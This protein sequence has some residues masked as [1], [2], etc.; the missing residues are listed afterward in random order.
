MLIGP[1]VKAVLIVAQF[2]FFCVILLHSN[3]NWDFGPLRWVFVSPLYHRWHHTTE[4]E[5]LDK[6]FAG[7]FPIWDVL[8]GTAHFP[9]REPTRFGVNHEAPPETLPGQLVYPFRGPSAGGA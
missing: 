4:A 7:T 2:L 1:S 9:R 5:G 3:V 6:N 8:F